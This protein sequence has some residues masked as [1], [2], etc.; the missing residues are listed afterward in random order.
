[1][2]RDLTPKRASRRRRFLGVP[3]AADRAPRVSHDVGLRLRGLL[4]LPRAQGHRR[5]RSEGRGHAHRVEA[6][7][8]LLSPRTSH[9]TRPRTKPR[10]PSPASLAARR[11]LAFQLAAPVA[12]GPQRSRESKRLGRLPRPPSSYARSLKIAKD[13]AAD[14]VFGNHNGSLLRTRSSFWHAP[15]LEPR[16]RSR[17]SCPSCACAAGARPSWAAA[18]L[19]CRRLPSRGMIGSPLR[20][21]WT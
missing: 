14:R 18:A 21:H 16:P 2:P 5:C 15:S 10:M 11:H 6:P 20:C 13:S 8:S 3:G 4:A 12:R 9:R 19:V 1:M 7:T 17:R